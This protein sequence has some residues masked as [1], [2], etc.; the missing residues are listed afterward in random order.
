M[1]LR[2]FGLHQ[3]NDISSSECNRSAVVKASAHTTST[4]RKR[5]HH[6]SLHFRH[7]R[8]QK[9]LVAFFC[10]NIFLRNYY[11]NRSSIVEVGREIVE[12]CVKV[13]LRMLRK[14]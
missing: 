14:P 1:C 8:H 3:V 11:V 7:T 12:Q 4:R 13:S 6:T 10:L 9:D 2:C 5:L